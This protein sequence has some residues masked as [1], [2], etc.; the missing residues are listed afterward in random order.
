MEE[1]GE[2]LC[3]DIHEPRSRGNRNLRAKKR[4]VSICCLFLSRTMIAYHSIIRH[5]A[6]NSLYLIGWKEKNE[7]Y[8]TIF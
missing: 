3:T 5:N 6:N 4:P 2:K 7:N 1:H 8:L